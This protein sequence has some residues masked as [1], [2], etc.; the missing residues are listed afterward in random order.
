MSKN[1]N[2]QPAAAGRLRLPLPMREH[3]LIHLLDS[4]PN[5][6][7]G[8]LATGASYVDEDDVLT[9]DAQQF[10]PGT[11]IEGSPSRF[12]MDPTEVVAAL[13]EIRE[14][15]QCLG[16]IVHSHLQGPATPSTTDLR[17][18]QYPDALLMIASFADQPAALR[19]WRVIP[20]NDLRV[21]QAVELVIQQGR[22]VT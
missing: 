7:V 12:T 10:F 22:Y 14:A 18:A 17:E 21:V 20:E 4:T 2:L 3:I 9:V 5:E 16:A 11:N 15:G 6:G 1:P 19:A 8:L 13:R